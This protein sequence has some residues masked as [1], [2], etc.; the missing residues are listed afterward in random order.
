MIYDQTRKNPG[1]GGEE[2]IVA[3]RA[4]TQMQTGNNPRLHLC[5]EVWIKNG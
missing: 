2:A 3:K 5:V 1:R 4:K